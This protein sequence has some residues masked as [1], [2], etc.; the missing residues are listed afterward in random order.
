MESSAIKRTII[1]IADNTE[2]T[3]QLIHRP[4]TISSTFRFDH[5]IVTDFGIKVELLQTLSQ[6]PRRIGRGVIFRLT[7]LPD[8]GYFVHSIQ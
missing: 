6:T 4:A 1:R 8:F 2:T 5:I 7:S 3:H